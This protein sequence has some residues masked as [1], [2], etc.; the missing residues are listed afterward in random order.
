MALDHPAVV[1]H[2]LPGAEAALEQ[3][4]GPEAGVDGDVDAVV[5]L[6]LIAEIL[7]RLDD[8]ALQAGRDARQQVVEPADGLAARRS[9]RGIRRHRNAERAEVRGRVRLVLRDREGAVPGP[10]PSRI[11]RDAG[12]QLVLN[13]QLG[14]PVEPSRPEPVQERGIVGDDRSKRP[15]G[16][17]QERAALAIRARARQVAVGREVPVGIGPRARCAGDPVERVQGIGH[18]ECDV[19]EIAPQRPFD[20]RPAVAEQVGCESRVSVTDPCTSAGR[21]GAGRSSRV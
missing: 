14:L 10:E 20:R 5:V 3:A 19:R 8:V 13:R 15:E 9:Q 6:V 11:Q 18:T 7:R 17:G 1:G 21:P 16:G 4:A 12:S 2:G